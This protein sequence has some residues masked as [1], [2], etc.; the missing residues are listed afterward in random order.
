MMASVTPDDVR[1]ALAHSVELPYDP[2]AVLVPGAREAAVLVPLGLDGPE[3]V[4]HLVVRADGLRD[5]AGEVGFPGGKIEPGETAVEAL[6][7][8]AEEE[9]GLGRSELELLG[10][11]SPTPVVT[12][13]FLLLPTVG[14]VR[15]PPRITSTEHASI[16]VL[17]LGPWLDGSRTVEVTRSPWRGVDLAIPHFPVADRV[18]YGASAV[19]LFELLSR[20]SAGALKTRLVAEKPWG[21]RYRADEAD[22]LARR[23]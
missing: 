8:E 16:H 20:L 12:G 19:I 2:R 14:A 13:K 18:M 6:Y 15:A 21:D 23:P 4:V 22:A 1:R 3:P 5:H 9:V 7:R 11:L 17:P 10:A